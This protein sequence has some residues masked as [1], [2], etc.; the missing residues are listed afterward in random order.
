MLSVEY[1]PMQYYDA[2]FIQFTGEDGSM[3]NIIVDGGNFRQ[4][5]YS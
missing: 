2:I 3:H 4:C 1:I 5:K